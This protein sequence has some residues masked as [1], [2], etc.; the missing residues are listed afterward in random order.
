MIWQ[1]IELCA[2][3]DLATKIITPSLLIIVATMQIFDLLCDSTLINL[4]IRV[5]IAMFRDCTAAVCCAD[6]RR[7]TFATMR[8]GRQELTFP[9]MLSPLRVVV[10]SAVPVLQ[11]CHPLALRVA[12]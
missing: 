3:H 9:K 7:K 4:I 11:P 1:V 2:V 8:L 10:V 12:C 5:V 6:I